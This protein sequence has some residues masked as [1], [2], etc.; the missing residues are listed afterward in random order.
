MRVDKDGRAGPPGWRN[1]S[2][3]LYIM[4]LTHLTPHAYTACS[5]QDTPYTSITRPRISWCRCLCIV[6]RIGQFVRVLGRQR[7]TWCQLS[8]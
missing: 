1:L 8:A 7:I 6:Q 5:Q 3:L 4:R 2:A